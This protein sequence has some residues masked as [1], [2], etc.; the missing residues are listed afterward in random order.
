[1]IEIIVDRAPL[2]T[3]AIARLETATGWSVVS[4]Y[5]S[6]DE[7]LAGRALWGDAVAGHI[8]SVERGAGGV[9]V[10]LFDGTEAFWPMTSPDGARGFS[11]GSERLFEVRAEAWAEKRAI[12][13]HLEDDEE[14]R[15]SYLE[16]WRASLPGES[17]FADH[18]PEIARE[19]VDEAFERLTSDVAPIP[20]GGSLSIEQTRALVAVDV[21][22]GGRKDRG[23]HR[24]R[25][26]AANRAAL[27]T[28]AAELE[29]RHLAGLVVVDLLGPID[30]GGAEE[31]RDAFRGGWGS[32]ST[33][34][35]DALRPSR[36]GLLE[37]AVSRRFAPVSD[38]VRDGGQR[39][40]LDLLR[41]LETELGMRRVASLEVV[42]PE[43]WKLGFDP[44]WRLA[45]EVL[46]EQFG[47]RF[48]LRYDPAIM[49]PMIGDA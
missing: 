36:L 9:F 27:T 19:M 6:A 7:S 39:T 42:C 49:T 15:G 28:L 11:E 17:R 26:L 12:V 43:I 8:R 35:L 18:P 34:K 47:Q 14:A 13:R 40:G 33:R 3:R 23:K 21:D 29:A 32:V 10:E 37:A 45:R 24:E 22:S 2:E 20:G 44:L 30:R 5:Q 1:M 46:A 16:R 38:P 48:S 25:S 4:S 31:L 41:R